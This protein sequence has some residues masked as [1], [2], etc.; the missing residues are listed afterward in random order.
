MVVDILHIIGRVF[1][2]IKQKITVFK[3]TAVKEFY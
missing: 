1:Y 3:V 2:F